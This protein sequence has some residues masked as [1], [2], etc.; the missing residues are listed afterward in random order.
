MACSPATCVIFPA[1]PI[2]SQRVNVPFA[3]AK[4]RNGC[5]HFQMRWLEYVWN[6]SC[7]IL[8]ILSQVQLNS[9]LFQFVGK[10]NEAE[11]K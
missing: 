6:L 3:T 9:S 1:S 5:Q 4:P 7:T 10:A 2:L 11:Y 8:V